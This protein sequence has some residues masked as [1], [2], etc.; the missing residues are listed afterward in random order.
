M[1]ICQGDDIKKMCCP[2]MQH[3]NNDQEQKGSEETSIDV[4]RNQDGNINLHG[5]LARNVLDGQSPSIGRFLSC[6]CP[7]FCVD[8]RA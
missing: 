5:A 4:P 3:Y 7:H 2:E 8:S 1:N 6:I